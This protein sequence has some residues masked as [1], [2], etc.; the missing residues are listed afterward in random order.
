MSWYWWLVI[1]GFLASGAAGTVIVVR[2]RKRP[3]KFGNLARKLPARKRGKGISL[4]V[5]FRP[6]SGTRERVWNWLHAYWKYEMPG[7]QLVIGSD[8]SVPFNK[9]V[10]V[11]SAWRHAKGDIFVILDADCYLPGSVIQD[12]ADRIRVARKQNQKLWFVP[13]RYFYRL[14]QAATE[15]VLVSSP[16]DPYR[17]SDPPPLADYEQLGG[18]SYGHWYGALIQIMPREAFEAAGGMDERFK[19]GWGGDDVALMNA[20]DTLYAPHHTT[21]NGVL[22]LWHP[23]LGIEHFERM[24]E[25]QEKPGGNSQLMTRYTE[26]RGR[27]VRMRVL[28]SEP[29]HGGTAP[30]ANRGG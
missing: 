8:S 11:N 10:A 30:D 12:C 6:D 16:R 13:Y 27:L 17:F 5:P 25:G 7:A 15:V 21:R 14:T 2:G 20:A 1:G 29:G 23:H 28:V 19:H 3:A 26:A 4:L 9:A 22:H 24:W 18:S